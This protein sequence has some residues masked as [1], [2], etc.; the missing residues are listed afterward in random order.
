MCLEMYEKLGGG[1]VFGATSL[2][3]PDSSLEAKYPEVKVG[4]R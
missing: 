2:C 3:L 1:V 4:R